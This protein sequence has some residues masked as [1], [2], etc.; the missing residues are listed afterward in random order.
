ML[1]HLEIIGHFLILLWGPK[2]LLLLLLLKVLLIKRG[3]P[4]PAARNHRILLGNHLL[5]H[6]H[7]LRILELWLHLLLFRA[8]YILFVDD[9][10]VIELLLVHRL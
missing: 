9:Q 5:G 2:L 4:H 7:G 8:H 3:R 6:H 1:L 10:L